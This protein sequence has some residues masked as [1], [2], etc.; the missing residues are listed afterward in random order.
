MTEENN[1]RFRRS[2]IFN[3]KLDKPKPEI[4]DFG[5]SDNKYEKILI[6]NHIKRDED[7]KISGKH[8]ICLKSRRLK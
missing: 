5:C 2:V 3:Y 8:Q 6:A 4:K 1:L 7:Y